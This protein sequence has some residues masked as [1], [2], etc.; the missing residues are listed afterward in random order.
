MTS[1]RA[2]LRGLGAMLA[3]PAVVQVSNIMPVKSFIDWRLIGLPLGREAHE[4]FAGWFSAQYGHGSAKDFMDHLV[5]NDLP[6]TEGAWL[7][8]DHPYAKEFLAAQGRGPYPYEHEYRVFV[9]RVV[10]T[11]KP[12]LLP[13]VIV[14][15]PDEF[16]GVVRQMQIEEFFQSYHP[17]FEPVVSKVEARKRAMAVFS[18]VRKAPPEPLLPQP[19]IEELE[20]AQD[21]ALIA[22]GRLMYFPENRPLTQDDYKGDGFDVGIYN[23]WK[24]AANAERKRISDSHTDPELRALALQELSRT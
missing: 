1:R 2:F 13:Q 11:A 18:K 17:G 21:R 5:S 4:G 7:Y 6:R 15:R 9:Q 3:A 16:G 14:P 10:G 24:K 20:V 22:S 23:L 19:T 12:D 8:P